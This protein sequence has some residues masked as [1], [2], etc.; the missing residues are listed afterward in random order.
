MLPPERGRHASNGYRSSAVSALRALRARSWQANSS[1]G[2]AADCVRLKAEATRSTGSCLR[3]LA[4]PRAPRE[5]VASEQHPRVC[6]GMLPLNADAT[7]ST[8]IVS[9]V[10]ALR[11]LRARSRQ[12]NSILGYATVCVRLKAEATRSTGVVF[13]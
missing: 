7:R 8:A 12:A 2:D 6:D 4:P 3:G 1:V 13:P 9:A 5:I 11:A 10:S